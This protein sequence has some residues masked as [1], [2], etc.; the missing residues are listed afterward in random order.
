M[1]G[2]YDPSLLPVLGFGVILVALAFWLDRRILH[3][4]SRKGT[5]SVNKF[6]KFVSN[7]YFIAFMVLLA[8]LAM[9]QAGADFAHTVYHLAGGA[10][11]MAFNVL[12]KF[13]V[14]RDRPVHMIYFPVI[15]LPDYSFPS[16]HSTAVF[17]VMGMIA[18]SGAALKVFWL[19]FSLL[20]AFSRI[21]LK[22][23]WASDVVSGAVISYLLMTILSY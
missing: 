4:F 14:R 15:R 12:I 2:L 6:M 1:A 18:G 10:G 8:V 17:A 13:I 3:Y 22:E 7:S 9:L 11:I 5:G 20:V 21:Y 19:G 23:H 16:A